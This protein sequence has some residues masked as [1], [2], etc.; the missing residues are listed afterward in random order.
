MT[1][2]TEVIA[3][4]ASIVALGHFNPWIFQPS[5][6]LANKVIGAGEAEATLQSNNEAVFKAA[7]A[8]KLQGAVLNVSAE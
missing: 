7:S 8:L 2:S 4:Q 6:L 3:S 1:T 5:W